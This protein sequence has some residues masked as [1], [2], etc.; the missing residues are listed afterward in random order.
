MLDGYMENQP[1][2]IGA[3]KQRM[4]LYQEIKLHSHL[5]AFELLL[6]LK[7]VKDERTDHGVAFCFQANTFFCIK[8]Y[9]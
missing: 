4:I 6:V 8:I 7:L 2:L 3:T 1:T 5:G 9:V